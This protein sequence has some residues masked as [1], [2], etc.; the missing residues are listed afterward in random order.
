MM[1]P[2]LP[3]G[4][5]SALAAAGA[6]VVVVLVLRWTAA[7]IAEEGRRAEVLIDRTFDV[8]DRIVESHVDRKEEDV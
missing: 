6:I 8:V 2:D 4:W 1:I 3:D 7:V 5:Q